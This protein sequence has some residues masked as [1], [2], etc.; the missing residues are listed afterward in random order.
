MKNKIIGIWILLLLPFSF[1]LLGDGDCDGFIGAGDADLLSPCMW[2]TIK[3]LCNN[4]Y[5]CLEIYDLDGDGF[6]GAGDEDKLSSILL[7]ASPSLGGCPKELVYDNGTW[8]VY[9]YFGNIINIPYELN[10]TNYTIE[11]DTSYTYIT[12]ISYFIEGGLLCNDIFEQYDIPIIEYKEINETETN[13]TEIIIEPTPTPTSSSPSHRDYCYYNNEKYNDGDVE[14]VDGKWCECKN[15]EWINCRKPSTDEE[16]YEEQ[17]EEEITNEEV[18][19][20]NIIEEEISYEEKKDHS[21]LKWAGIFAL[22]CLIG[23]CIY[24]YYSNKSGDTEKGFE[25]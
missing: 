18:I 4:N 1:A 13:E 15:E 25:E 6:I 20:E 14:Y 10:I 8:I 11:N 2:G 24:A 16:L 21:N 12:N 3:T 5:T 7:G 22:F 23:V 19:K 9:N 17:K